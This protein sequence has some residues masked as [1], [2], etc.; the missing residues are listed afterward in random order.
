MSMTRVTFAASIF[1][2]W[3]VAAATQAATVTFNATTRAVHAAESAGG[4]AAGAAPAGGK[5]FSYFVTTDADIL[6]IGFV[7]ITPIGLY[8]DPRGSNSGSPQPCLVCDAFSWNGADSYIDTPGNATILGVDMPGD[9]TANSAWGDTSDNGP[10][11][12]FKF[13][14]LT[15]PSGATG[16]FSGNVTVSGA[17]GPESF[18]FAFPVDIPEPASFCLATVALLGLVATKRRTRRARSRAR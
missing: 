5:V 6:S 11:Q 10:Q 17:T 1:A 15:F 3:A 16:V 9:G 2:I 7:N 13:A 18:N 4:A 14:Q 8:Q 12:N